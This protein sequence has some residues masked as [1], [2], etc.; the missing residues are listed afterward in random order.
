MTHLVETTSRTDNRS[1]STSR[2]DLARGLAGREFCAYRGP[3]EEGTPVIVRKFPIEHLDPISL[4]GHNDSN[5]RQIEREPPVR[6]T[7][8]DGT[9]SVAGDEHEV[10]PAVRVLE[11]LVEL[12]ERGKVIEEADVATALGQARRDGNGHDANGNGKSGVR[13]AEAYDGAPGYTFDRK[14]VRPRTPTQALYLKALEQNEVVFGIGPAGTGRTHLAAAPAGA[15]RAARRSHRPRA[16]RGRGR[17]EPGLPARRHAGEGGSLPAPHVR[18]ARRPHVVRQDAPLPRDGRDRDRA[19]RVHARP[20]ALQRVRDPRRGAEHHR[21][22][23]ENVP[24]PPRAQLARGHH[25]RPH[26]DRPAHARP[27]GPRAHPVDSRP[28]LRH[29][30]RVLPPGR[31]RAPPPGEGHHPRVRRLPRAGGAFARRRCRREPGSHGG[32]RSPRRRRP[33]TRRGSRTSTGRRGTRAAA[34]ADARASGRAHASPFPC[35]HV[36]RAR[37]SSHDPAASMSTNDLPVPVP[38]LP[39]RA[40]TVRWGHHAARLVMVVVLLAAAA[41]LPTGQEVLDRL[42]YRE[43]DIARERI[44]APEDFRI[45]KD[46]A[47]LR[48]D[49]EEAALAVP[50][51]YVVDQRARTDALERWSAFQERALAVVSDPAVSPSERSEKLKLLGVPLD[52]AAADALAVPPVYVVD[53]R[54]R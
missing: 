54:A 49:L 46:D 22:P 53:Q 37:R 15:A 38:A 33:A 44:V 27:V 8:R 21:A 52:G 26:P 14:A 48:R 13:L 30:V 41:V 25:R 51:V 36:P 10:K 19:A 20:H 31:R 35:P 34:R 16:P 24:H 5:V 50:P 45:Q 42:R 23:D 11:E 3:P 2:P 40:R 43:G 39:D 32:A 4:L 7:L 28:R 29:Q 9:L 6:I 47:T 12:A 18:R 1:S 17:G